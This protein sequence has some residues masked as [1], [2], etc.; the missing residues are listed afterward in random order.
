VQQVGSPEEVYDQ[1]RNRFVAGFIGS[2]PVNWIDGRLVLEG[3]KLNFVAGKW[4]V[5]LSDKLV[6]R[7]KRWNGTLVSL[8]LRSEAIAVA[9]NSGANSALT[10]EIAIEEVLGSD[11]LLTLAGDGI[12]LVTKA[13][14]D[15]R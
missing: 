14:R 7:Y 15:H 11:R 10:M 12:H 9:A 8:G 5:A 13:R 4:S 2:P 3:S 6:D 1:P